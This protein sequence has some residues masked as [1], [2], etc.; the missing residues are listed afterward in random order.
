MVAYFGWRIVM[1]F[2]MNQLHGQDVSAAASAG[3]AQ[4]A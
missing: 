1:D 4:I 2:A 3:Q